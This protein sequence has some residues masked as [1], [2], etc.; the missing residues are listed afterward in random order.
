MAANAKKLTHKRH[1]AMIKGYLQMWPREVFDL[2]NSGRL[3]P[4]LKKALSGPG[5]Y[6]LYRDD[7]PYYIGKAG[8][9]IYQ[10]LWAHANG[11]RDK[12]YHFWNYFSAYLVPKQKSRDAIEAILIAAMP[13]SSNSS[14]P[15]FRRVHLPKSLA[16]LLGARRRI[17]VEPE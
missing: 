1:S 11:T 4:D 10:R 15:R 8:G 5:V 13:T 16:R 6:I 3:M 14:S 2:R 12:H 9:K 17:E 7:H